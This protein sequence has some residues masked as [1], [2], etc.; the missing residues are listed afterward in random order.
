MNLAIYLEAGFM[1]SK[2][3]EG[4]RGSADAAAAGATNCGSKYERS[5]PASD[6][7]PCFTPP[8]SSK[9]VGFTQHRG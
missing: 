9:K 1:G 2:S 3:P 4:K 5:L 7:S 8:A 6:G